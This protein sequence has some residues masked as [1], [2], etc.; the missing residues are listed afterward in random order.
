MPPGGLAA[1]L[2]AMGPWNFLFLRSCEAEVA[3]NAGQLTDL[4]H[5]QLSILY[6]HLLGASR[7]DQT[8]IELD[9][10]ELGIELR[11]VRDTFARAHK[12]QQS[13]ARQRPERRSA[14]R[15]SRRRRNVRTCRAKARAPS[16]DDPSPEPPLDLLDLAVLALGWGRA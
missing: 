15:E 13:L 11:A 3:H 2:V 5:A 9:A 14:R 4:E 7:P 12:K 10:D 8:M 1:E 6:A 16:G